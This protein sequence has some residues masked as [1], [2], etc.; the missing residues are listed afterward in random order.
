MISGQLVEVT[1][2]QKAGL[3]PARR[4]SIAIQLA[5]KPASWELFQ[6]VVILISCAVYKHL[7]IKYW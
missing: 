5:M 3:Y 2:N 4:I 7:N 6:L 1:R